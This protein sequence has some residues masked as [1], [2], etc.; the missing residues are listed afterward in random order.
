MSVTAAI[1]RCF[2]FPAEVA[3]PAELPI[4]PERAGARI[5]F[6]SRWGREAVG[7]RGGGT[8]E[9][10]LSRAKCPEFGAADFYSPRGLRATCPELMRPHVRT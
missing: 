6:A 10:A 3:S 8:D 9:H 4:G 1:A 5:E 7:P 2:S